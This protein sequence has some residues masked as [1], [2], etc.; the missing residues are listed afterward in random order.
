MILSNT[1]IHTLGRGGLIEPFDPARLSGASYDVA[2]HRLIM[3]ENHDLCSS[4]SWTDWDIDEGEYR[5]RPGEFILAAI[6]EI[7]T[8][9]LTMAAEFR[10]KSTRAREGWQHNLAVWIDPGYSGRITL[11]LS[12]CNRYHDL[13]VLPGILIGQIIW[14]QLTEA[15]TINYGDTGNYQDAEKVQEAIS[16]GQPLS[17]QS[18]CLPL[19]TLRGSYYPPA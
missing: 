8:V 17:H 1:Q 14:H 19:E 18:V 10:L 6:E 12:N 16:Q 15:A 13:I 2:L 3:V 7:I 5:L 9:P 11:E 4:S